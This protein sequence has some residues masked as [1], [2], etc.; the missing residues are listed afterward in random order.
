MRLLTSGGSLS[1]SDHEHEDSDTGKLH[2]NQVDLNKVSR[3]EF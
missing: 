1:E 2:G 3:L